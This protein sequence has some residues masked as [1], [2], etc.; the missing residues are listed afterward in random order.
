MKRNE[1]RRPG[2]RNFHEGQRVRCTSYIAGVP[3]GAT[4][5]VAKVAGV[6]G[7][8]IYCDPSR[9]MVF[10]D[11]DEYPPVG[12]FRGELELVN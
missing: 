3:Y 8:S 4:G 6:R 10:V 11:W 5:T 12:V 7:A 1:C 9:L 2:I